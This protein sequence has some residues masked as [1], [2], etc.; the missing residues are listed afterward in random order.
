MRSK[1]ERKTCVITSVSNFI[2]N[3]GNDYHAHEICKGES[4]FF[5]ILFLKKVF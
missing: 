5:D 2:S 4:T 3:K 1:E